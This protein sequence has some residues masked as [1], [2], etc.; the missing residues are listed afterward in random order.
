MR[1][2]PSTGSAA[3]SERP[4]VEWG[5][6]TALFELF[7][8]F[9]ARREGAAKVTKL[10]PTDFACIGYL[11]EAA[12]PVSAKQIVSYLRLTSGSGTAL[13]DRLEKTGL[14]TRLP[15]PDDR[16]GVLVQLNRDAAQDTLRHHRQNRQRFRE[17]I[18]QFSDAELATVVSFLG[19]INEAWKRA[20][21]DC[22]DVEQQK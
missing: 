11:D 18:A 22:S 3:K 12:G 5:V 6:A 8:G 7:R 15:N 20:E 19:V 2:S 9:E 17:A 14:I 4:A 10:H 21:N 13:L 1:D 16:R